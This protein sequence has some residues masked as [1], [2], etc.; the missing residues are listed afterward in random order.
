MNRSAITKLQA[1]LLIVVVL[2]GIGAAA[3][4]YYSMSAPPA[5]TRLIVSTTTSLYETGFLD[6]LKTNFE[7]KY[8]NMNVSFIS[9]G[10]GLAI[11]TAMRGDADMLLVHAPSQELPFLQGGYGVNRKIIAYN[12]F[13]I[14]GSSDD[15]AGIMGK[16]PSDALKAIRSAGLNG[17]AIWVSR[18]DNSGTYTKE[19]S[20]W[21][22]AGLDVKQLRQEKWYLEAGSGMTA[23]LKLANEKRGY[24]LSDS[25]SYLLNFNNHNID[26]V[27]VVGAS[28]S[29]LNVYSA[30]ADDPRNAN[31]TKTNFDGS[32][33]LIKYLVSDEG[34]QLLAN[35][36]VSQDGKPAFGPY[37]KLLQTKNDPLGNDP[38]QL[39]QWISDYAFFQSSECPEQFRYEAEGLYSTQAPVPVL[40][41]SILA[42]VEQR[43]APPC[44]Q[45]SMA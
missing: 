20:L 21:K 2:C 31:M 36:A 42:G 15:P 37:V 25:A 34:Q 10:T 19:V 1:S 45:S 38:T 8:P 39:I 26:L 18:G 16:S 7:R 5:R 27:E 35:Y 33:M 29:M 41:V 28:K 3:Y 32:M 12:F 22:A 13:L 23:T 4:A 24:T 40:F 9:Q 11:Q 44:I 17:T 43:K 14:V 6:Y 30:I